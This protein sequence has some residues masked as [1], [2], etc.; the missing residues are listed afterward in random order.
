MQELTTNIPKVEV[1]GFYAI[2]IL[3]SQLDEGRHNL[4]QSEISS[5]IDKVEWVTPDPLFDTQ[6]L[7]TKTFKDDI[8]SDKELNNFK[9]I[10]NEHIITYC[11]AI[12][13]PYRR[14]ALTSWLTCNKKGSYSIAHHHGQSHLSG[15]YYFKTNGEDG[16]FY[17]NSPSPA[18]EVS[19]LLQHQHMSAYVLPKE[20]MFVFFPSFM[21]HGVRTNTTDDERISL[22][23]NVY[24]DLTSEPIEIDEEE[25]NPS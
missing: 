24:F 13:I 5:I 12:G 25:K 11:K 10:L 3:M 23:F 19:Y 4:V 21:Q 16:A 9:S 7:S 2:P 20:G 1:A 8:V 18:A 15:V 22:S 14:Y 17:F 6:L